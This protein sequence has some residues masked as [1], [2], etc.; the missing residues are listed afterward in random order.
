[1]VSVSGVRGVIGEGLSP[2]LVTNFAQAFGAYA[3][4]GKVVVGRD[5]PVGVAL[6]LQA[7]AD[8]A[9]SISGLNESQPQYSIT[10]DKV[11]LDNIE[12]SEALDR[13]RE[14]YAGETLDFTDGI[15]IVRP[16]SWIHVR[17]SNT[18][19]VIRVIAEAPSHEESRKLCSEVLDTV[20]S[21]G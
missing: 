17:P 10:K 20:A 12:P 16:Q 18:E 8:S 6:I 13:I 5:A 14:I 2:E 19:P 11:A 21:F 4:Q 9:Q 15:K 7:L 1:M 3:N